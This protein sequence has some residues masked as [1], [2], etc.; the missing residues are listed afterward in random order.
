MASF[1]KRDLELFLP[2]N[3]GGDLFSMRHTA[4]DAEVQFYFMFLILSAIHR[5]KNVSYL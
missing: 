4:D 5:Y 1:G 3:G 2:D